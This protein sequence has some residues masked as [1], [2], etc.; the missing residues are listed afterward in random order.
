M[1]EKYELEIKEFEKYNFPIYVRIDLDEYYK[2]K[3]KY[4]EKNED[5]FIKKKFDMIY[6]SLKSQWVCGKISE[7]VFWK[8]V[9]ILKKGVVV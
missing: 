8:L 3:E 1:L 7:A 5:D 9:S 4:I 2:A 6:T